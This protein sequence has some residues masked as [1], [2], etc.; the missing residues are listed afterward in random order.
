M[1]SRIMHASQSA[2]SKSIAAMEGVLGFPLFIRDKNKLELTAAGSLLEKEWRSVIQNMEL[3]IHKAFL[4]YEREQK[5]IVIG[6]PDS[7]KT[8]KDYWPA[9]EQFQND[10]KEINLIFVE[11][12]ISELISKLVSNELDIIFT[13]DYEVPTLEKLGLNWAPVADSPF[14]QILVHSS[15]PLAERD[16]ITMADLKEEN[17][18]VMA[19]TLHQTY[20]D[21]LFDLCRPYGFKP[22]IRVT[23]P[24][25]RSMIST[26][27]RTKS[28]VVMANRFLYDADSPELRHFSLD[29]T[30]SRLI[31]A[32]KDGS[33]KNGIR[34]FVQA[35]T[36]NYKKSA[37]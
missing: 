14:I 30:Y 13:I 23:V 2:V 24:N 37:G 35:V 22:H 17:F 6:E 4:L 21:L 26:L 32:W 11:R 8:D 36:A 7:M 19:P 29:N 33:A 20:I 10:H 34:D 5:S 1:A 18:I 15:H 3:A 31:V 28:G 12:P 25:A 16:R 9:I 27:L